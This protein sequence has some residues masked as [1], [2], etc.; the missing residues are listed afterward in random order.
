MLALYQS[1]DRG[2][3]NGIPDE[4]GLLVVDLVILRQRKYQL[5]SINRSIQNAR[6][7]GVFTEKSDD[8]KSVERLANN[9]FLCEMADQKR[10]R[11]LVSHNAND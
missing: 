9:S 6:G 1:G 7:G 5:L 3:G 2:A 4:A 11:R 10:A 8:G